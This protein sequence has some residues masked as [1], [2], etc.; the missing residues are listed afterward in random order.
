MKLGTTF[1]TAAPKPVGFSGGTVA[2]GLPNGLN[3]SWVADLALRVDV[4]GTYMPK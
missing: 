3:S 4:A 1:R 2:C